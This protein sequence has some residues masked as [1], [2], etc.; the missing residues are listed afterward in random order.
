M[1]I[2][3][4]AYAFAIG[5][6]LFSMLLQMFIVPAHLT[7]LMTLRRCCRDC[8]WLVVGLFHC[9]SPVLTHSNIFGNLLWVWEDGEDERYELW[10]IR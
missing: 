7:V 1:W 2:T 10:I 9:S 4:A 3:E 6:G 5:L 8:R